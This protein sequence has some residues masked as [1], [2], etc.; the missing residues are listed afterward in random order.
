MSLETVH[1]SFAGLCLFPSPPPLPRL[2]AP[3]PNR[4][5]S[6]LKN[7]LKIIFKGYLKYLKFIFI[8]S[9]NNGQ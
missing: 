3:L 5:F 1:L 9:L 8:T 7:I 2:V 6:I 4:L